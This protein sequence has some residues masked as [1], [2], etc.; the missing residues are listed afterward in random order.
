MKK[1]VA[2]PDL[3][4]GMYV[5]ELD[6]AW[7]GTPFLFQGFEIRT[8]EEIE[9][10]RR[11]CQYV[12][13][14]TELGYGK[15]DKPK[16]APAPVKPPAVEDSDEK[17]KTEFSVLNK[18]SAG[19]PREPHYPDTATLEGELPR[20]KETVK[21]T[22]EFVYVLMDDVR[23]GHAINSAAAK[24]V[25]ADM[26]E[27]VIRNPDALVCLNQLKNK[28]EYTALHSLRV[29]VL[30]LAFGR[31][32]EFTEE[33][34]NVLGVGALLH[35]IG[36]MK[37]P[38]E[39]LN[40][41]GKLTDREFEIMKSHVP[42]GVAILEQTQGIVPASI[43]VA[44]LHHER[45]NGSGYANGVAGE[46][47][48]LFGSIGAI[49]DCY[50]AITSDRAYHSG[51][52]SH[53]AL[54]KMYEWR[55]KD[56]HPQLVEQFIQCMG[57]YPIGSLVELSTGSIGVV[58]SV[59]RRRRLKPRVALVLSPDKTPYSSPKIVDLM[60]QPLEGPGREIEIRRVLPAGAHG[61]NPTSY[62]PLGM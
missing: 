36:K 22:K 4:P 11:H 18:F 58:I 29:C 27:S 9:E 15:P 7:V 13:I 31:H 10:L 30:A 34:L 16:P 14:D 2:V 41:P 25:V 32:L 54:S 38:N 37:V 45:Y 33:E 19:K 53:D 49:V 42:Q 40:K 23:L 60:Q 17:R 51:M 8:Q 24:K 47:I 55:N 44:R 50:D 6:R 20:A 46:T 35:D 57:I 39:I 43:E 1:K 62:I 12:F 61:I 52:T 56:F 26:V 21:S 28:D 48:G 59:N 3:R 5:S